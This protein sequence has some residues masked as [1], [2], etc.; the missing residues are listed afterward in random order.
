[1]FRWVDPMSEFGKIALSFMIGAL[2]ACLLIDRCGRKPESGQI[3]APRDTSS[4]SATIPLP[5][6]ENVRPAKPIEV[7]RVVYRDRWREWADAPD[8]I[9]INEGGICDS[10]MQFRTYELKAGSER[11][12]ITATVKVL[13]YLDSSRIDWK[14]NIPEVRVPEL[15]RIF[16]GG[17]AGQTYGGHV[18]YQKNKVIYYGSFDNKKELRVGVAFGF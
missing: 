15:R 6:P 2:L 10:L 1:M 12:D 16:I 13:G 4:H 3:I 18:M 17:F 7:I 5:E 14:M 11:V 8:S 9:T